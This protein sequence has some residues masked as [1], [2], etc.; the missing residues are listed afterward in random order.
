MELRE[1]NDQQ[2]ATVA[3]KSLWEIA[4]GRPQVFDPKAETL[5][6]QTSRDCFNPRQ[7]T[8]EEV[9][10]IEAALR[11]M[12][13]GSKARRSAPEVIPYAKE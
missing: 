13:E 9:A 2:I 3:S 8:K 7:Y 11:L 12:V 5:E 1:S 4:W 6:D 10:Q